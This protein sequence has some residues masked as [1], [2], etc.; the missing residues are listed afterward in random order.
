MVLCPRAGMKKRVSELVG[1]IVRKLENCSLVPRL[2]PLQTHLTF[3]C[4]RIKIN[5]S[6][7]KSPIR[8][9]GGE[10]EQ[11]ESVYMDIEEKA[12]VIG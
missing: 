3:D 1:E 11:W 7:V 4:T 12:Y 2:S 6:M 10:H 9:Q 8:S 5:S